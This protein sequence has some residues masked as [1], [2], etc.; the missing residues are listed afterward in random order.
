MPTNLQGAGQDLFKQRCFDKLSAIKKELVNEDAFDSAMQDRFNL[1]EGR[2][3]RYSN[4][5]DYQVINEQI[6]LLQKR[7][8]A[9]KKPAK[10]IAMKEIPSYLREEKVVAKKSCCSCLFANK[11]P[12]ASPKP[13]R[14]ISGADIVVP[15]EN[16]VASKR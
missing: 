12:A 15:N 10:P 7:A 1:L 14:P 3:R 13:V 5:S 6:D 9:I 8:D 2:I 4:A 16:T 11:K